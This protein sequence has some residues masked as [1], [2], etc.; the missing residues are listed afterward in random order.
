MQQTSVTRNGPHRCQRSAGDGERV[1][2]AAPGALRTTSARVRVQAAAMASQPPRARVATCRAAPRPQA[3]VCPVL[4]RIPGRDRP[5]APSS[6]LPP[7]A[8]RPPAGLGR[9]LPQAPR[10]RRRGQ[11]PA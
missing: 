4:P 2:L 8:C 5:T 1:E 10:A 9:P 3:A 6:Q 7:A 11:S